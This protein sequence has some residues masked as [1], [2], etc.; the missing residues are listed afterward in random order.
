MFRLQSRYDQLLR[1]LRRSTQSTY[2][3]FADP[4]RSFQFRAFD[5]LTANQQPRF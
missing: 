1:L 2:T 3:G 4:D 5:Q